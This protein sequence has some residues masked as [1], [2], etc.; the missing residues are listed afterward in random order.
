MT[1]P[2]EILGAV[3]GF[4]LP[5]GRPFPRAVLDDA[6]WRRVFELATRDRLTPLLAGAVAHGAL[7][8][9][10]RQHQ[11]ATVAH[12]QS[13]RLC[14]LL[15]RALL[16]TATAF[17]AS[18]I[19]YRV[20][21][22]PAVAHLDYP[23]PAQ[24]AFGDVD[25][26]VASSAYDAA[27]NVLHG[28][29]ARRRFT[30]VRPGFDRRW[31]KGACL[32]AADGSQID[33]HR[34]F[35]AGPFGLTIDLAELLVEPG[36]VTIGGRSLPVLDRES[37]F[38]HACFHAAL[39]DQVARFVALRDVAQLVLTT[40]L[41]RDVVMERAARWRAEIV[42][43]RAVRLS[44]ARLGLAPHPWSEW[45]ARHQ[46][47]RFQTRALRAYTTESRSYATQVV[48]GLS[49]VRGVPEKA[50]YVR[51][52]LLAQPEHLA[53]RDRSYHRRLHRAWEAFGSTRST[54]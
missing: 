37:R 50:A 16:E 25:V 51:A 19:M 41:D 9:S 15:E 5:G 31:G 42:V 45:A 4:G 49:A 34:T 39:G 53:A 36:T 1:A 22:G 24:R 33:V 38:L 21:K 35:V 18:G 17:E 2:E 44:W 26:L 52:L 47:D 28:A 7:P 23:D 13:M 48:A 46:A 30:E 11:Q 32:V 27:L 43:A 40:D 29:G 14:L 6:T 12:E 54:R 10:A 8:T 20:L 3:A